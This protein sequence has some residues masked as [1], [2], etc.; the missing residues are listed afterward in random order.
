MILDNSSASLLVGEK[1]TIQPTHLQI[2][3]PTAFTL[4]P[5]HVKT[6]VK[7]IQTHNPLD[8]PVQLPTSSDN[9]PLQTRTQPQLTSLLTPQPGTDP[10]PLSRDPAA[11]FF[12]IHPLSPANAVSRGIDCMTVGKYNRRGSSQPLPCNDA[13]LR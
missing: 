6:T 13:M 1:R 11:H 2:T 9:T 12:Y 7:P 10:K 5:S 8:K 4:P 3:R